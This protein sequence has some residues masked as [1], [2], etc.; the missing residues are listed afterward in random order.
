MNVE[1]GSSIVHHLI[2]ENPIKPCGIRRGVV[3][4]REEVGKVFKSST[5]KHSR[6]MV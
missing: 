6:I 1:G 4:E 5:E 3:R 2:G